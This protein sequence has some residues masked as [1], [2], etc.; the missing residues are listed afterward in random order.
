[1]TLIRERREAKLRHGTVIEMLKHT[2]AQGLSDHY[3]IP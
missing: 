1:M 2:F 3:D